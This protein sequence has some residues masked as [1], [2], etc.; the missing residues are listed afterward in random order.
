MLTWRGYVNETARGRI[1]QG[2]CADRLPRRPS[3]LELLSSL[4]YGQKSSGDLVRLLNLF[5]VHE[6]HSLNDFRQVGE[7]A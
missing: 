5:S 3:T 1:S 4:V 2:A 6:F 7:A